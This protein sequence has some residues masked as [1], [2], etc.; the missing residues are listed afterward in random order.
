ML[1]LEGRPLVL[2]FPVALDLDAL[3]LLRLYG[4]F[5]KLI[6]VHFHVSPDDWERNCCYW[7]VPVRLLGATEESS[8]N[9]RVGNADVVF[10]DAL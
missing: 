5:F 1:S 10:N 9:D 3:L 8:H 4:Q 7:L 6:S 2:N